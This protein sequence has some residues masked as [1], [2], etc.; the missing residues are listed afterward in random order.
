M[1]GLARATRCGGGAR[2]GAGRRHRRG[3]GA[4]GD[5]RATSSRATPTPRPRGRARWRRR[6]LLPKAR[7]SSRS[8]VQIVRVAVTGSGG[9]VDLRYQVLDPD[10]A[11]SLHDAA[12]PPQLVDERTGVLVDALFMEP[13]AQGTARPGADVLPGV[14]Q[15]GQ[16]RASRHPRH[17]A[18]RG[19]ACR[20]CAGAVTADGAPGLLLAVLACAFAALAPDAGAHAVSSGATGRRVHA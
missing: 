19:G 4:G 6:R 16:P 5:R 9:L 2:A 10:A 20:A 18:A 8:G 3:A 12:T 7:S 14:R 1:R 13:L 15:P 17:R 11:A